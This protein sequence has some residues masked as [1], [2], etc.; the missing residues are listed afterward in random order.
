V[1]PEAGR[2]DLEEMTGRTGLSADLLT[3]LWRSL[4]YPEPRPGDKAFNDADVE[5]LTKVG[6]LVEADEERSPLVLQIS[7]VI[8]SSMSRIA[9]AQLDV[10]SGPASRV[11]GREVPLNEDAIKSTGEL[12]PLMPRIFEVAWRRHLQAAVRRRMIEVAGD[13]KVEVIV[14]F[15]DLV[16][17]TALSQQMNDV[18]LS[19]VVGQ[20]EALV[21]D[22]ITTG[23]GRVVKTIGDEVMFSVESPQAAAEIALSLADG[24]RASDELS[25][26]RVGMAFGPVLDRDGDL[27]G[28]VV[29]LASRIT[30]IALPGSVVVGP[31]L[32]EA[33]AGDPAYVVR[34]MRPR[35]LKHIGRVGL[36]VIRRAKPSESGRFAD[37]RQALHDAVRVRS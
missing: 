25:D 8:G 22:V 32:A 30:A 27:Y 28:P 4:G 24:A 36:C 35:Y 11:A 33:L 6:E 17:F 19:G 37:R 31:E 13:D 10:I 7:R 29:N 23:G 5:I 1:V 12:L 18:E 34:P 16:G 9:S 15:A 14:G 21:Y 3:R 20:F 26:V 2:Y